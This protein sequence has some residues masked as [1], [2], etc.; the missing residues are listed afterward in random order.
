MISRARVARLEGSLGGVRPGMSRRKFT[1]RWCVGPSSPASH[2]S[3]SWRLRSPRSLRRRPSRRC[4]TASTVVRR[5]ASRAVTRFQPATPIVLVVAGSVI[6]PVVVDSGD[7][8]E[9]LRAR[10]RGEA[11]VGPDLLRVE[12]MSVIRHHAGAGSLSAAAANAAT[13]DLIELPISVYPTG[14]AAEAHLGAARQRDSLRRLLCRIGRG[15]RLP[16]PHRRCAPFQRTRRSLHDRGDIGG[17]A[18]GP[19]CEDR[20]RCAEGRVT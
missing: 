16:A 6:A 1:R 20:R 15:A 7:D 5:V 3:G 18:P 8:G 12:V 17:S 2:F 19:P 13:E 14:P 11:L 4:S 9:T 10:L